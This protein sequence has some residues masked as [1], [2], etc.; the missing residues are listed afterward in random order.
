MITATNG[1]AND[2]VFPASIGGNFQIKILSENS[3]DYNIRVWGLTSAYF[4]CTVDFSDSQDSNGDFDAELTFDWLKQQ[5]AD[6]VSI[7][8]GTTAYTGQLSASFQQLNE[9]TDRYESNLSGNYEIEEIGEDAT[10]YTLR[11]K[12][13]GSDYF[14]FKILKTNGAVSDGIDPAKV[15]LWLLKKMKEALCPE[16]T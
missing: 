10:H 2:P 13:T 14:D 7:A 6:S 16:C 9:E 11:F 3:S 4:D 8:S 5:M 12:K 15:L 1:T